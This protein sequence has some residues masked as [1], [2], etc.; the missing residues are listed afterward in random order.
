MFGLAHRVALVGP[1]SVITRSLRL[2]VAVLV[3]LATLPGVFIGGVAA[4]ADGGDYSLDFVAAAPFTY[5]HAVGGGAFN[6]RTIGKSADVVESLE[7]GDFVCADIVTYFTQIT[8]DDL[9]DGRDPHTTETIE[10]SYAFGAEATNGAP[11]GH[12]DVVGVAINYGPVVNGAGPG[13]LDAGIDDDGGST[14]VIVSEQFTSGAIPDGSYPNP[15]EDELLLTV[16]VDDLESFEAVVLRIDVQLGCSPIGGSGNIQA[17]LAGKQVVAADGNPFQDA[18]TGGAQTIPFKSFGADFTEPPVITVIKSNDADQDGTF[19]DTETADGV[20]VTVTYQVQIANASSDPAVIESVADDIHDISGSTCA[21]L[22]GTEVAA[23]QTLTCTFDVT[24]DADDQS[25]TNVFTATGVNGAGSSTDADDSTVIIEDL[26]PAITLEK[27]ASA[28]SVPETGGDV[29]FT[30]TVTNQAAEELTLESL[31]DDVFGDLDG[32]G[33]CAVP[34]TLSAD[35][36]SYSCS[37]TEALLGNAGTSHHNT[38]T[39][40]AADDDGNS[41]FAEDDEIVDF[42]DVLPAITVDKSASVGTV[43][44]AGA[45]VTFTVVVTNTAAEAITLDS[46]IDDVFGN[47]D[48]IGSCSV[49]QPLAADGGTYECAFT[50]FV[51]GEPDAPHVNVVTATASDDDGNEVTE[52]DDETVDFS[53]ELPAIVVAK[54]ANLASVPE[55]GGDVTFTVTVVNQSVES[56]TLGALV[57][58]VFGDLDGVGSCSVPQTLAAT[59]GSYECAFTEFLAGQPD[60]PHV[61]VVTATA[62]DDDG[63]QA[64][65]SDDETVTFGDSLPS[66]SVVKTASTATVPESGADVTFT[67]TVVNQTAETL[68][69]DSLV[70]DVFGGLDGVGDCG[71]PQTLAAAG[72]SYECSFTEFLAGDPD[73]PHQNVVT[74]TASDDDGNQAR[75]QDDEVVGFVDELP[76]ITVDKTPSVTMVPETGADVTFTVTVVNESVEAVELISLVDDVFG[77]LDGA[78]SCSVSQTLAAAGGSYQCTFTEFLAG[79]PD[80]PHVNVVTA[81]AKDDDENRATAE[82]DAIVEFGDLVPSIELTKD[83]SVAT[84]PETGGDVT[85]SV[86][87]VNTGPTEVTITSLVDDVFGDLDGVGSCAV[88]QTL[89]P[90]GGTYDCSFTEPL[91]GV[92]S[93]PHV[94]VVTVTGVDSG[95]DEVSDADDATVGFDPLIDLEVT[96]T[97]DP[98]EVT[99]GESTDFTLLVVNQGPSD[100]TGVVLADVAPVELSYVA[101][102]GDGTFEPATGTWTIGDLA[103]G[104]SRSMMLT[105]TVDEAGVFVTSL[106]VTAADQPDVDSVPGDGEGDDYDEAIVDAAAVLASGTIG[107]TVW[108]DT[109]KDGIEDDGE[110]GIAGATVRLE[111]L[112]TGATAEATTNADGKY[113]FAA[114]EAGT[115]RVVSLQPAGDLAATTPGAMTVVLGDG[116][117]YLDADFGWAGALPRTGADLGTFAVAGLIMLLVGVALVLAGRRE[118]TI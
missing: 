98:E 73:L 90:V 104:E 35:G 13:G 97:A 70:D 2:G 28:G 31:V 53:D 112:D 65:D 111:N 107:D 37:F 44:E 51:A 105:M 5:D 39:G 89:T 96:K 76:V 64:T 114:L 71:V 50:E 116:E 49:P 41:A 6:D 80:A 62:S 3:L 21:A 12:V 25:V 84:V 33:T 43:S 103:V 23:G 69:L 58:D 113:L 78:G 26:L 86:V 95:G 46:L 59:G 68:M 17:K 110:A 102:S 48:G 24:F 101:H 16:R 55:Q 9:G 85:F 60:A 79:S 45:D 77:D 67:V 74:A 100:A 19:S 30:V 117:S 72:G 36:G 61:N 106:E 108:L 66:I 52:D 82:D 8:V 88:P 99:V 38:V 91:S 63:N 32:V 27:N 42:S 81:T 87:V 57:D 10:L 54:T 29:T 94:N 115:Y 40:E 7:G 75:A 4:R 1:R 14:A 15:Q 20:P 47:L 18:I 22:I 34:Q 118:P 56:L 83:A 11:V 109:D 92:P 93:T